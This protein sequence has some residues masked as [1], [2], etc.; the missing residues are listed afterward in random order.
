VGIWSGS[1]QVKE[2]AMTPI[3]QQKMT[4]ILA[5]FDQFFAS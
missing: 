5:S 1:A 4:Q 3:P 2:A